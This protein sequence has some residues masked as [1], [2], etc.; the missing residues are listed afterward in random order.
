MLAEWSAKC[1]QYTGLTPSELV[2]RAKI[3]EAKRQLLAENRWIKEV[4]YSL[5][6]SSPFHFSSL[7]RRIVGTSP[8][9]WRRDNQR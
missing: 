6:F 4:A 2:H 5:A 7:F 9:R 8:D 1:R 3:H